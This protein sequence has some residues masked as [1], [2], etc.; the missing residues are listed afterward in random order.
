MS[1][2]VTSHR[3][4]SIAGL[5]VRTV[6]NK[7]TFRRG[8][9]WRE[10]PKVQNLLRHEVCHCYS[11]RASKLR[12][13]V[14]SWF[15]SIWRTV[16]QNHDQSIYYKS[17]HK[18]G[19]YKN[20]SLFL[21]AERISWSIGARP[22]IPFQPSM[23]TLVWQRQTKYLEKVVSN[24]D[25][26]CVKSPSG[27]RMKNPW[28]AATLGHDGPSLGE[29][30]TLSIKLPSEGNLDTDFPRKHGNDSHGNICKALSRIKITCSCF[31]AEAASW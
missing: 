16:R 6:E 23:L 25:C 1:R 10:C 12:S 21:N 28:F 20:T 8:G 3:F 27:F 24:W 15:G 17:C 22:T 11:R 14:A 19:I 7:N 18:Y 9:N 29:S 26:V 30:T 31:R 5:D 2:S 13:S 4:A